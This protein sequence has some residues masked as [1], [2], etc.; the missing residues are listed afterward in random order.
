[1]A[2][3]EF[4]DEGSRLVEAI[5][6][7]PDTIGRRQA[8]LR[9]LNLKTGERVLDIGSGPGHQAVEMSPMVGLSGKVDGID[10]SDSMLQ[11]ARARCK[12]ISNVEFHEGDAVNL[13]FED[14][15]FD[16]V[17]SSMVF[18]YLPDVPG[19]LK[20]VFRVLKSGG[21]VAIHGC[22]W[23]A[24]LW[25]SSDPERMARM[26]KVWDNHL[27]DRHLP[28]TL[29]TKLR[30]AGFKQGDHS[31]YVMFNPALNENT[32]SHVLIEFVKAYNASQGVSQEELDAWANDLYQLGT[33][34]D[35][36]Y[37]SNEYIMM[38]I[39]P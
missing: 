7:V 30:E 36:F 6:T 11:I 14:G 22:D 31:V 13:S 16:A 29:N 9:A 8:I 20:E 25:R 4:D 37:S 3:L 1:M 38:G 24:I 21:R 39:K 10:V 12:D 35:Y 34:G 32:A 33:S 27:V 5:N 15:T 28:Q 26:L 2:K 17:I 18:E 23:G 19:A